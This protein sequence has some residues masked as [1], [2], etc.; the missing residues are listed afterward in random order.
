MLTG[1]NAPVSAIAILQGDGAGHFS[2]ANTLQLGSGN[3][4]VV[5][6]VRVGDFNRDGKA[7]IAVLELHTRAVWVGNR[8]FTFDPSVLTHFNQPNDL[9]NQLSTTYR[10]PR[11]LT[12]I[13]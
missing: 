7:D 10:N 5:T 2:L 9:N 4:S 6:K 8:N 3:A 12:D 13:P 11:R 1:I